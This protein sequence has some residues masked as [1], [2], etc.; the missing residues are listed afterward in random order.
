VFENILKIKNQ[1]TP[2]YIKTSNSFIVLEGLQVKRKHLLFKDSEILSCWRNMHCK[3]FFNW[4]PVTKESTLEW[5]LQQ[6]LPSSNDII[7]MIKDRQG[8]VFGCMAIYNVSGTSCEVGRFM[9]GGS[10]GPSGVMTISLKSML[11]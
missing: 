2:Y 10:G 5:L 6:Y 1:M 3:C 11:S 7:F 8:G 4:T 9:R